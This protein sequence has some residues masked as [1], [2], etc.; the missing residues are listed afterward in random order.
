MDIKIKYD[1]VI[2]NVFE[3]KGDVDINMDRKTCDDWDSLMHLT[4]ITE[5]EDAF[6][7]ILDTEDILNFDSYK[8]GFSIIKKYMSI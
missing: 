1:D 2:K 6:D 5:M 8:S 3:I 4:L 7:I